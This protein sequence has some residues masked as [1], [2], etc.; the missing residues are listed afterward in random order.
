[1]DGLLILTQLF[2]QQCPNKVVSLVGSTTHFF[3]WLVPSTEAYM[4]A[5][6]HPAN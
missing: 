6:N 2:L 5:L 1:M 4:N 3:H